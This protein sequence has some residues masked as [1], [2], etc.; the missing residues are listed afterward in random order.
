MMVRVEDAISIDGYAILNVKKGQGRNYDTSRLAGY[1]KGR[2]LTEVEQKAIDEKLFE[3]VAQG[4][5]SDI[6][7]LLRQGA[8]LNAVREVA[9][10]I[11]ETPLDVAHIAVRQGMKNAGAQT[12]AEL[13]YPSRPQQEA[14]PVDVASKVATVGKVVDERTG[15]EVRSSAGLER[16]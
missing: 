14:Q 6:N 12:S 9:E 5:I 3:A 15:G 4:N 11:F 10:G 2:S 13:G 8:N 16:A 1:Q 7:H